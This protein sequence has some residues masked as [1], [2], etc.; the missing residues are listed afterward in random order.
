MPISNGAFIRVAQASAGIRFTPA[1]N[2]LVKGHFSVQALKSNSNAGLGGG[3]VVAN[4]SITPARIGTAGNDVFV[5]TYSGVAPT[6][7][8]SGTDTIDFSATTTLGMALSISTSAIQVV[9]SE[10]SLKLGSGLQFENIIGGS[11]DD[12]LTG[13]SLANRLTGNAWNDRLTG[14][15]LGNRLTGDAGHD[16][17]VGNSGDDQLLGGAGRELPVCVRGLEDQ[18]LHSRRKSTC[19]MMRQPSTHSL[20]SHKRLV[21]PCS[22]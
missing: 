21:L 11:K 2:S 19:S 20:A 4:I 10:L 6:G 8:V 18:V 13:N 5:L 12:I 7:T 3:T 15:A 17:L 22:I 16:I 9:N 1:Q 14:N